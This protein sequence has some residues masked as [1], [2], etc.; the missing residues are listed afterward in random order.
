M[1]CALTLVPIDTANH[2]PPTPS[3]RR[4]KEVLVN[5]ML[6]L[7]RSIQSVLHMVSVCRQYAL[8]ANQS[9]NKVFEVH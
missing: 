3:S 5:V 8:V 4:R 7:W 9:I 1:S 6:D 2:R